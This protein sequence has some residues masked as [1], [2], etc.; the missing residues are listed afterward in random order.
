MG[1]I[2]I[3]GLGSGEIEQLPLGIYRIL[4]KEDGE[5][6][7]RTKE[8]PVIRQ[9]EK[10][11]VQ[12]TSFDDLYEANEQFEQVYEKITTR[13]IKEANK[14][15]IIYAVP[16]HPMVA[17]RT[18]QLLL[19]NDKHEIEVI[20]GQS[21]L[22]SLF[23][24]L[25]IDPIEGFQLL[26]GTNLKRE[27]IQY[28]NHI[29]ISQVYDQFVASH[30]KLTLLEDLPYDYPIN[31]VQAAGT[32]EELIKTVPLYELDH[33]FPTNNLTTLYVRPVE[34][35][36]LNHQ[37][38]QLREVV[39]TLR[40]PNG[41]PWDQKQTHES[42]RKYLIE[43]AYEVI[44]AIDHK[45]DEHLAEELGDVLL[46]I[47]L[48]SQIAEENGYFT[49]DDVIK[50]ITEKMIERHP[51]VF[52]DVKVESAEEVTKNWE[53]IKLKN[54]P[55]ENSILDGLNESLPRLLYAFEIQ[56]KVAKV[57][58]DWEEGDLIFNK[59]KEELNEFEEAL[60]KE[61]IDNKEMEFG[62]ILFSLVNV[63]RFYNID[64]E[65]ALNRTCQKF[66]KRFQLVEK[67]MKQ[68]GK[69]IKDETLEVMDQYWEKAK[70]L[71]N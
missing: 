63:A 53:A 45:D 28:E 24:S 65:L 17:E 10:E 37:F 64:P 18:V 60:K 6:F 39:R 54:K 32:T 44:E 3:V 47:M 42:L 66:I 40:G 62:D 23:T 69:V 59:V 27:E 61:S 15:D 49:V 20:G 70:E 50:N 33:D 52:G 43:E 48:H 25:K 7:T 19:E 31:I 13:L 35:Q 14:R 68:D 12:F 9:L 41:C 16:G 46:Q 21:F 8:H 51:H 26:D 58:F 36:L 29:V 38:K 11:G 5:I 34:A 57:G 2:T 4:I 55:K 67:L 56:K 1:M 71:L 22:D 30:V